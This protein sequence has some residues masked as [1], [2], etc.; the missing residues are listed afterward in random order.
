M[1]FSNEDEWNQ[2]VATNSGDPYSKCCVDFAKAWAEEMEERI[3]AGATVSDCAQAACTEVDRRPGFG[4]TGFMY[5]A[6]VSMLSR[7]WKHGEDLRRW[8][9]LDTQLG[10]EGVK[11]NEDGGV[12]NP[13]VVTVKV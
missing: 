8:H 4:I 12:L 1:L 7:T 2:Y 9:N 3:A 11:A 5:G 6:A 13:A 10:D